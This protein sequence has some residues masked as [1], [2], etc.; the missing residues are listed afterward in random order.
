MIV[1]TSASS[2]VVE[3]KAGEAEYCEER[4]DD[5]D[6][7]TVS[8]ASERIED[9][10]IPKQVTRRDTSGAALEAK[11]NKKLGYGLTASIR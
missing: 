1:I 9:G 11:P 6:K 10:A 3:G 5:L 4:E 8:R 7:Q 2:E